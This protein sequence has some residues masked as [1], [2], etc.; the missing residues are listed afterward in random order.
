M[1]RLGLAEVEVT[2]PYQVPVVCLGLA[3]ADK[4]DVGFSK[5]PQ[6]WDRVVDVD[7]IAAIIT[8]FEPYLVGG[9]GLCSLSK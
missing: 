4:V 3:L 9:I 7:T 6:V 2:A 5:F 1:P 8:E